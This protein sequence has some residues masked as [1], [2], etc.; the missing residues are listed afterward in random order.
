MKSLF[1]A[2]TCLPF[3]LV[4]QPSFASEQRVVSQ[5]IEALAETDGTL[6]ILSLDPSS[7]HGYSVSNRAVF[8]GFRI[9]GRAFAEDPG[10]KKKLILALAKAVSENDGTI[11]SCFNPRHGLRFVGK[12]K[13]IELVIC[14]ECASARCHGFNDDKGILLTASAQPTFDAFLTNKRVP[15]AEKS[16]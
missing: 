4:V 15:L 3:S 16:K 14:F 1:V 12:E 11:A 9:L 6:E 10:D 2:L 13:K 7:R 5:Q 8:H